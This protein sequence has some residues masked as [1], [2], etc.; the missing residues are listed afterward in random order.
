MKFTTSA[1]LSI[2]ILGLLNCKESTSR[3]ESN[4]AESAEIQNKK[5]LHYPAA[6]EKIF[7]AHGGMDHWKEQK[8]LSFIMDQEEGPETHTIDL[9]SRMDKITGPA[10]SMGYDGGKVWLEEGAQPYEGDAIFYHNLMFYFYAMPFVLGDAGIQYG[11]TE[12]LEY[13]GRQYPGLSIG[14][15]ED[16]GASPK[17]E[18]YL[19][20][21]PETYRMAWL[22]YTVTYRS[23]APSDKINWIRYNDWQELDGLLLPASLTWYEHEGR[24]L[25][26]PRDTAH[27]RQATVSQSAKPEPF[28]GRPDKGRFVVEKNR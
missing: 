19:H 3:H 6:L 23:G 1:L 18:Y 17:D 7:K 24:S 4:R 11:E 26:K 8:T 21:D 14:F 12:M 25:L 5:E 22:G 2:T 10:Y 15:G 28:Y 20:Y 27:F 9:H 13:E 16:V